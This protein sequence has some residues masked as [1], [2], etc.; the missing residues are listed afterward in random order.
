M[1][2][3]GSLWANMVK[4]ERKINYCKHLFWF[5]GPKSGLKDQSWKLFLISLEAQLIS[6]KFEGLVTKKAS[7]SSIAHSKNFI[8]LVSDREW[9][10]WNQLWFGGDMIYPQFIFILSTFAYCL[11]NSWFVAFRDVSLNLLLTRF[12]FV[13]LVLFWNFD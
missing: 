6:I 3:F 10:T 7:S 13:W 9:G 4:K 2:V 8:N 11:Q 1:V 12:S 5:F